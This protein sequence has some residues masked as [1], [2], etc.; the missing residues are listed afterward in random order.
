[1]LIPR[2]KA[3]P[4][5]KAIQRCQHVSPPFLRGEVCRTRP[6]HV[7]FQE[8]WAEPEAGEAAKKATE[9][10][11]REL[12][13]VKAE[14]RHSATTAAAAA[15]TTAGCS[16]GPEIAEYGKMP[17]PAGLLGLLPRRPLPPEL[18]P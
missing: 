10:F 18:P 2:P 17:L 15:T 14:R 9:G 11:P 6:P 8:V 16:G 3:R 4:C 1:M 7:R 13:R 5:A 12:V